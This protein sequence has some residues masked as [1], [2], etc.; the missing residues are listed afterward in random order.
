MPINPYVCTDAYLH[1]LF[2]YSF[3]KITEMHKA[4]TA[5]QNKAIKY[6]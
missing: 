3:I 5:F 2:T 6:A 1:A 4:K